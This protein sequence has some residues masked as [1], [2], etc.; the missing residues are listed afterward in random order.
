MFIDSVRA[1]S[2]DSWWSEKIQWY[3][4]NYHCF[5][6][7]FW[8][9]T[10][11]NPFVDYL[12]HTF[13]FYCEYQ[14]L[15]LFCYHCEMQARWHAHRPS[16]RLWCHSNH[17]DRIDRERHPLRISCRPNWMRHTW[18]CRRLHV[19]QW[20]E[21]FPLRCSRSRH[22]DNLRVHRRADT[23]NRDSIAETIYRTYGLRVCDAFLHCSF[24]Y[25]RPIW[26][27]WCLLSRWPIL[28]RPVK[29]SRTTLRHN[30]H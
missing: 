5:F 26:W 4:K 24:A 18:G 28:G 22:L 16:Y 13:V 8:V 14:K 25:P 6:F 19:K 2:T 3:G 23:L 15:K 30:V 20:P 11:C 17:T 21:P 1:K 27:P 7:G 10:M 29:I 9:L 12:Q